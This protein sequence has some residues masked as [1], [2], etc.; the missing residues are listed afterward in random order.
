MEIERKFLVPVPP[1]DL[2]THPC[3]AISQGYLLPDGIP[4]GVEIRVRRKENHRFV[5]IKHGHGLRRTE[6]ELPLPQRDFDALWPLTE[7]RRVEKIRYQLPTTRGG[8]IELDVYTGT[9]AGLYTAEIEFESEE[10]GHS[11]EPPAFFGREVTDDP[12]YRNGALARHGLP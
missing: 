8:V 6:V 3:E 9:L 11:F 5:T 10:A 7:D 1:N 2:E 4:G 12:A